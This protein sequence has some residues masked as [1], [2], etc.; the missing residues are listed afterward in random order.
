MRYL[1]PVLITVCCF[2][3]ASAAELFGV[4]LASASKG[5]LTGA[6][7]A[8]GATPLP[9]VPPSPVY[10]AFDSSSALTES[11]R[12]YLAFDTDDNSF[13]F[14]EYQIQRLAHKTVLRKLTLKYGEPQVTDGR[15][16]SDQLFAWQSNG[17]AISL[18]RESRCFCS[19]LRYSAPGKMAKVTQ[20]HQKAI[21]DLL[22]AEQANAY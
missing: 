13:A 17:I 20:Q 5:A 8:A 18:Q 21:D 4:Q 1:L 12:L 15:F 11:T 7:K 16:L 14:A 10:E 22:L 19:V 9:D 2:S 3:S 6:A